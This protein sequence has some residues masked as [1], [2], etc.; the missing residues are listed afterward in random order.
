LPWQ[1]TTGVY[2]HLNAYVD[3]GIHYLQC[4]LLQPLMS[5]WVGATYVWLLDE[6]M[7]IGS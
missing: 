2:A 5:M 6:G 3:P 4:P 7:F 1:A